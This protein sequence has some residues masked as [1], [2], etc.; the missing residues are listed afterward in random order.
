MLCLLLEDRDAVTGS[1]CDIENGLVLNKW[2]GENIA[3]RVL[4][5]VGREPPGVNNICTLKSLGN[6]HLFFVHPIL[7]Q[8]EM[9]PDHDICRESIA[10]A[11]H[12]AI[13]D[14]ATHLFIP[15]KPQYLSGDRD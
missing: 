14:L 11:L 10:N 4:A 1:A 13:C 8:L 12:S 3:G 7:I 5:P 2:Q 9:F 15:G 6:R